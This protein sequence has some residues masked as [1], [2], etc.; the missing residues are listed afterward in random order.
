MLSHIFRVISLEV[1]GCVD[2]NS[3]VQCVGKSAEASS[4]I[5]VSVF[6]RNECESS[7]NQSAY[8]GIKINFLCKNTIHRSIKSQNGARCPMLAFPVLFKQ[9]LLYNK[10]QERQFDLISWGGL[11]PRRGFIGDLWHWV[12]VVRAV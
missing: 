11:C 4:E 3:V 10:L 5:H 8:K 1:N 6:R 2:D 7:L 12:D 9:V